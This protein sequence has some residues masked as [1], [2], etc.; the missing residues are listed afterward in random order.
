MRARRGARSGYVFPQ[1]GGP[2]WAF[3]KSLW[4]HGVLP[5]AI[6]QLVILVTA[7]TANLDRVRGLGADVV[8]DY[9]TQRFEDFAEDIDVVVDTVGG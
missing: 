4:E 7:S 3:N 1:F 9:R 6:H 8:V 5:A 2:A